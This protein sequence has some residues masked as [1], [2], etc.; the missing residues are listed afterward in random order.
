MAKTREQKE[1]I[2][3]ELTDIFLENKG[4]VFFDYQGLNNSELFELRKSLKDEHAGLKVAKA[5]L[6]KI[7]LTRNK[8]E[9]KADFK[10]PLA[11]AF[12]K[13]DELAPFRKV[14]EFLKTKEKGEVLAGFI[15]GGFTSKEETLR[16][17]LLPGRSQLQS[18]LL[19]AMI[20]PLNQLLFM[21]RE[22]QSQLL[23]LLKGYEEQLSNN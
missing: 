10:R 16:L 19:L 8:L 14:A 7:A 11:L 15:D 22:S 4:I 18:S 2:I 3:K 5:T 13:E 21:L 12:A 9:P 1:K 17:A 6:L 20:A 23:R